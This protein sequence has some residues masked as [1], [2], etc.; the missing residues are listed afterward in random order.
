M[1]RPLFPPLP[2]IIG[3]EYDQRLNI[4]HGLLPRPRYD[5]IGPIADPAGRP[6][7]GYRR[8]AG[9]RPADIRRGFI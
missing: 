4:P 1:P 6:R 9:G 2:G 7:F 3:G 5:P 8:P